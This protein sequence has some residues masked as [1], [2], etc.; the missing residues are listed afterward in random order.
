[1][2]AINKLKLS[3]ILVLVSLF[4]VMSLFPCPG[5]A[6]HIYHY[7]I[8]KRRIPQPTDK[9]LSAVPDD[10][11]QKIRECFTVCYDT[12]SIWE[13]FEHHLNH[14]TINCRSQGISSFNPEEYCFATEWWTASP[15]TKI[16]DIIASY[17]RIL[18][19]KPK[20]CVG[21]VTSNCNNIRCFFYFL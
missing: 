17:C 2:A 4:V 11:S 10:Q 20:C 7:K 8:P 12:C 3:A 15:A 9:V 16:P 18:T 21:C 5:E 1:M 6:F 19:L 13:G 14:C